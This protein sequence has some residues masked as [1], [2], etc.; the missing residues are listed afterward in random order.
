M[1]SSSRVSHLA[2]ALGMAAFLAPRTCAQQIRSASGLTVLLEAAAGRYEIHSRVPDWAFAGKL[3]G[4][5]SRVE[6]NQGTDRLGSYQEISFAE[7]GA[8]PEDCR[9]RVY[10]ARPVA[11]FTVTTR[12]ALRGS[13]TPFPIS[14]RFRA[15]CI[16]SA[17][18]TS[19][20]PAVFHTGAE[21]N[22][23]AP[24]RRSRPGRHPF[25]GRRFHDGEHVGRW[26]SRDRLRPERGRCRPSRGL[27]APDTPGLRSGIN[28]AWDGWGRALTDL[29]GPG[30]PGQRRR[31][32]PALSGYWTDNGA[33]YY[34]NYDSPW[35]RGNAGGAWSGTTA[36]EAIPIRY[37]QLDSWWYYKS[38]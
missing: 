5:A 11:L 32:R 38:L 17:I 12:A 23:L 36:T 22:A 29:G 13:P 7:D 6:A 25:A 2:L 16:I 1:P 3:D 14:P 35:L 8:G 21:R 30:A 18:A 15:G 28:A 37:L 19:V 34:Y 33:Y 24:L 27:H 31:Y 4:P 20:L 26:R 9:I 10:D